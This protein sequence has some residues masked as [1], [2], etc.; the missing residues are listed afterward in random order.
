VSSP[1]APVSPG[2]SPTSEAA[3]FPSRDELALAWGDAILRSLKARVKGLYGTGR[4]VAVDDGHAVFG[5]ES[6]TL[7]EMATQARP[8]VET[9][10]AAHF[11]R[12][13]PVRIV[14]VPGTAAGA[15]AGAGEPDDGAAAGLDD[16]VPD[17]AE[18]TDAPPEER[19]PIDRLRTAFPGSELLPPEQP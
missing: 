11:G 4:F 18:L 10:L 16:E 7:G 6:A 5:F 14:V 2:G 17:L 13:V 1:A 15:G 9:A 12:P 3:G 8:D 19:S